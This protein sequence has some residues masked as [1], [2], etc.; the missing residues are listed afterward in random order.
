MKKAFGRSIFVLGIFYLVVVLMI[1]FLQ[2]K[3]IF[4]SE[5]LPQ[6]HVFGFQSEH[7]ELF[8]KSQDGAVL[9]GVHFKQKNPKGVVLYFHGNAGNVDTWGYW[10]EQMADK[11]QHDVVRM[12]YRGYGKSLGNR[13]MQQMLDDGLLFY[14]YCLKFFNENQI[15]V[16]GRSL[17]GAFASHTALTYEPS[18][19]ILEST[20]TSIREVAKNKY[21]FLPTGLLLKY[22]F[23]NDE[24]IRCITNETHI[25][26]GTEDGLVDFELGKQLFRLSQSP[27]KELFS[28][29]GG[30]HNDLRSHDAYF[31]A[32]DEILR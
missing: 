12:D 31:V 17:G 3:L 29:E 32:L 25:I 9:H 28:I 6:D 27:N 1:T 5:T 7:K 10:A 16:F 18:K 2:E 19:L 14:N 4:L 30:V 22:P 8:L 20:F 15:V 24:N 13:S 11:Y 21:W 23:Q 26:H